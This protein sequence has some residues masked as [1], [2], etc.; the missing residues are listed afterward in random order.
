LWEKGIS[1]LIQ[2]EERSERESSH[3]VDTNGNNQRRKMEKYNE[4]KT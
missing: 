3:S 1:P 4:S 2:K